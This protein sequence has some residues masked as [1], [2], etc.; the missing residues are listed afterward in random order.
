[1]ESRAIARR[2]ISP[3]YGATR[4]RTLRLP[5]RAALRSRS[6]ARWCGARLGPPPR[7]ARA[8]RS[9]LSALCRGGRRTSENAMT[10]DPFTLAGET[11]RSRLLLGT[12]G[13]PTQRILIDAATASGC[14]IVTV[15]IRRISLQGHGFDTVNVLSKYR[16][17]PNTAG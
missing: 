17:L 15:S 7:Y 13:Y 2:P 16:F 4:P 10:L 11:F 5:S 9:R 12:A 3:S 6:T 1:M 14:E 8:T